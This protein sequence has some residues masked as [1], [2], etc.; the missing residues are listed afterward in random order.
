MVFL[1][2][3]HN[4][5]TFLILILDKCTQQPDAGQCERTYDK[6]YF[7]DG[8][9]ECKPF[10]YLGS[11]GN[12]NKHN[13]KG[14]CEETCKDKCVGNADPGECERT[15][16]KFYFDDGD[17]ECKPFV[18]LGSGGNKNKHNSKSECEETC[19]VSRDSPE[20]PK[21][22][23]MYF[24]LIGKHQQLNFTKSIKFG[25]CDSLASK[26]VGNAD[27]GQCERT[28]SKFYF[29]DGD[30]R[31]KPFLYLGSGGN[32]NKYDS[33]KDC[34][35]KCR[36]PV[37]SKRGKCELQRDPGPCKENQER[38]FFNISSEKCET[39]SYGGCGGNENNFSTIDE[40]LDE[41]TFAY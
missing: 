29:D 11:G 28:Y 13:S 8:D 21:P 20:N 34:D 7:D 2:T 16:D 27:P 23:C 3:S 30:K 12:K 9:K 1:L 18:Y 41:C 26:C 24:I 40:C 4:H 38:F 10:V 22:L 15:Y 37:G 6:F 39:F 36:G 14:E 33:K 5:A 17:K 19:K 32:E 35:E 31:C 25:I